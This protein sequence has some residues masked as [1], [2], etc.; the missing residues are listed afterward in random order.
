MHYIIDAYN[1]LHCSHVLP[2]RWAMVSAAG[3]CQMIDASGLAS[4]AAVVCDGAPKPAELDF[5]PTGSARLIHSG[6][7]QEADDVIEQL[8]D[9]DPAPRELVV[10][11]NDRRVQRAGR[12]RGATITPSEDFLRQLAGVLRQRSTP[13]ENEKP[14]GHEDDTEIWMKK[15]G[16]DEPQD[17]IQ[18]EHP[19]D[20]ETQRWMREFGY[21]PGDK[22]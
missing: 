14:A 5:T 13:A 15:F 7:D 2:E 12:R 19:F 11:S 20:S 10:V 18:P 9:R 6:A 1:V 22:N 17:T 8:I 4:R 3:L 21:D 16:L